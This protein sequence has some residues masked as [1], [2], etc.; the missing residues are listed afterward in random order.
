MGDLYNHVGNIGTILEAVYE[1]LRKRKVN[2]NRTPTKTPRFDDEVKEFLKEKKTALP[3]NI[4]DN[5]K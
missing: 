5:N 3:N 4:K 1:A 2:K